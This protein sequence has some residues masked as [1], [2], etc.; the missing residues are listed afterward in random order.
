MALLS[1]IE[2]ITT[3]LDD[4]KHAV[5][6]SMDIKKGFDTIDHNILLQKINHYGHRGIVSKWICSY[7]ESR[8]QYV[9]F[10]GMKSGLQNMTCGVPQGSI[11]GPK[12]FSCI[13]IVF[14]MC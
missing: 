2:N 6:V 1:L 4:H 12:F 3:S 8:S 13:S 9:Q 10:N 5:G 11:L 7:L 14:A